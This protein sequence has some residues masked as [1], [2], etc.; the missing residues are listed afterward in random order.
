MRKKSFLN[1]KQ[2]T[3]LDNS[4][5]SKN[6]IS[7]LKAVLSKFIK[8]SNG[9]GEVTR[10]SKD[11]YELIHKDWTYNQKKKFIGYDYFK[12]IV[13]ELEY[14]KLIKT[15][16]VGRY[17]RVTIINLEEKT[18]EKK[19]CEKNEKTLEKP[20]KKPLQKNAESV[21]NTKVNGNENPLSILSLY[22][23]NTLIYKNGVVSLNSESETI[24]LAMIY[25][26]VMELYKVVNIKNKAV[27]KI[28]FDM[29]MS[30]L[31]KY[32]VELKASSCDTYLLKCIVE[33]YRILQDLRKT[34][35]HSNDNYNKSSSVETFKAYGFDSFC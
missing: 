12:A 10:I 14:L 27:K 24:P 19:P 15:E 28:I 30:R 31:K 21:A 7:N 2:T 3:I 25:G 23:T 5:F 17:Q 35:N 9:N 8:Y 4:I 33:K 6:K 13:R 26:K 20:S 22:N 29:I 32:N 16:I 18:S 34:K 11:I 1:E